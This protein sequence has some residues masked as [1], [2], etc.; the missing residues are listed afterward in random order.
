[1]TVD[2]HPP[3][4]VRKASSISADEVGAYLSAHPEFF[5]EY[6]DILGQ[7]SLSHSDGRVISL[8]E[9]QV[10][11]LREQNAQAKRRLHELLDI[12]RDN[13]VL[14]KK[15]QRLNLALMGASEPQAIFTVL[16]QGLT[17]HFHADCVSARIFANPVS[18]CAFSGAE[19]VGQNHEAARLFKMIFKNGKVICG[20]LDDAQRVFLFGDRLADKLDKIVSSVLAPLSTADWKGIMAIGSFERDRFEARMGGDL[21]ASMAEVLALMLKPWVAG[22]RPA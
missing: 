6:P 20:E 7:L 12:A 18:E 9:K 21:L 2:K 19:F 16:Y 17:E 3:D 8:M 5:N 10:A 13:E 1:M 22:D 11:V 4:Y 15:M 14:A